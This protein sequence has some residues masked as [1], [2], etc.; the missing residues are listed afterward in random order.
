MKNFPLIKIFFVL[1]VTSFSSAYANEFME[2][3]EE[4]RKKNDN[5][6]FSSPGTLNE[7]I[8]KHSSWSSSDPASLTYI[9]SRC[10]ILFEVISERYKDIAGAQKIYNKSLMNAVI[11]SRA[12]SDIYKARCINLACIEEEKI[13]SQEREKKWALIYEEEAGININNYGEMIHSNI[14]S[15]FSTCIGKVKPILK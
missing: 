9:A 13:T 15:D 7:Y 6:T 4:V 10:G 1:L 14:K 2:N 11:F 12:S 8:S 5:P 3:L